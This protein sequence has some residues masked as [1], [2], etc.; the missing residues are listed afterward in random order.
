ML[1]ILNSLS[2][3]IDV[4]VLLHGDS[5][6]QHYMVFS[7]LDVIQWFSL[8]FTGVP[9]WKYRWMASVLFLTCFFQHLF[10]LVVHSLSFRRFV[11]GSTTAVLLNH[12][13]R[14]WGDVT[15]VLV[16]HCW[17]PR[18]RLYT[19]PS[20]Y[21]SRDTVVWKNFRKVRR[22]RCC[23][24]RRSSP[25]ILGWTCWSSAS[26]S[27]LESMILYVCVSRTSRSTSW[28]CSRV[29]Y[30]VVR[31]RNKVLQLVCNQ[32]CCYRCPNNFSNRSM[33]PEM[34][35]RLGFVDL[36]DHI[37]SSIWVRHVVLS[38]VSELF[39]RAHHEFSYLPLSQCKLQVVCCG[40]R[41]HVTVFGKIAS[42]SLERASN[43]TNI[44]HLESVSKYSCMARSLVSSDRMDF[45][46]YQ[47][48]LPSGSL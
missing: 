8:W 32:R 28:P 15:V 30:S 46:P 33:V 26:G 2:S 13:S 3:C 6:V 43:C 5:V 19:I 29:L 40:E 39:G 47:K 24:S 35:M 23:S 37:A 42:L 7:P 18:N 31:L 38:E 1:R 45:H 21:C 22:S 17:T 14:D 41:L 20:G 10:R 12:V 36:V 16:K 11:L 27:R 4:D 44:L 25:A 34:I 9:S 48:R